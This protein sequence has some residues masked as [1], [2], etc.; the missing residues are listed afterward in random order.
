MRQTD[1]PKRNIKHTKLT[2]N[3]LD[4]VILQSDPWFA[5]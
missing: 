5:F 3:M 2:I 1:L 4:F